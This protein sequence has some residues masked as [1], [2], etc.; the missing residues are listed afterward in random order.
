MTSGVS[1]RFADPSLTVSQ[2][3]CAGLIISYVVYEATRHFAKT[4]QATLRPTAFFARY[5]G[6]EFLIGFAQTT[7]DDAAVAAERVRCAR[8]GTA[9]S[10]PADPPPPL[11]LLMQDAR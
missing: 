6:E 1:R 10:V 3:V 5:G 7:L 4:V 8:G 11:A 9:S 2:L